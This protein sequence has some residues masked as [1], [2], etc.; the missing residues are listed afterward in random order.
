MDGD[1]P[2]SLLSTSGSPN[3]HLNLP[4]AKVV[5]VALVLDAVLDA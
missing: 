2:E 1:I 4:V 3:A 5:G